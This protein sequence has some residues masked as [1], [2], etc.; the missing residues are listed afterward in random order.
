MFL[1]KTGLIILALTYVNS[2]VINKADD[3]LF[4][5]AIIHLNDFHAR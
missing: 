5:V 4:P 1:L 2:A 3:D